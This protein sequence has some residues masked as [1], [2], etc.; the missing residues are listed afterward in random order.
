MDLKNQMVWATD[1]VPRR[2]SK[3]L[4]LDQ[5]TLLSHIYTAV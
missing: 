2:A 4:V 5:D 3:D 1:F